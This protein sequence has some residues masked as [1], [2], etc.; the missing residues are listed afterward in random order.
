MGAGRVDTQPA[1]R[2]RYRLA[3]FRWTVRVAPEW[4]PLGMA[5]AMSV[6]LQS[7]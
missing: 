4:L 2:G 7:V 3:P 6:A 1:A 5:R